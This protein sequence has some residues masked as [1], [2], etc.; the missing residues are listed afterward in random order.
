MQNTWSNNRFGLSPN[1]QFR[2]QFRPLSNDERI[3]L[4]KDLIDAGKAYDP[5][6]VRKKTNEILDG[7][8]RWEIC[9]AFRLPYRIEA[10][11]LATEQDCIAWIHKR[12]AHRRNLSQQERE[13]SAKLLYE[14]LATEKAKAKPS[15]TVPPKKAPAGVIEQVAEATG[16]TKRT[17]Q[18]RVARATATDKLAPKLKADY[19]AGKVSLSDRTL[20]ALTGLPTHEQAAVYSEVKDGGYPS[21][22]EALVAHGAMKK[23]DPKPEPQPAPESPASEE[24][25]DLGGKGAG[26]AIK[27]CEQLIRKI[28]SWGNATGRGPAYDLA[29]AKV[30]DLF[31]CLTKWAK[32]SDDDF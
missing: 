17:V 1:A 4:E 28:D 22:D 14:Q 21:L 6:I 26:E 8:N 16:E 23:P 30:D 25:A 5:V 15:S 3:G 24:L 11:D 29:R 7:H 13:A 31:D 12:Q 9:E 10:V 18:R 19:E 20:K 2:S 32:S 27:V